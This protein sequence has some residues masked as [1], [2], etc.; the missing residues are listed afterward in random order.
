MWI[1][2]EVVVQGRR[3][4]GENFRVGVGEPSPVGGRDERKDRRL[5]VVGFLDVD[6][7]IIFFGHFGNTTRP[8]KAFTSWER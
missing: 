7:T 8:S 1:E 4:D 3:K 5:R 6:G 2:L